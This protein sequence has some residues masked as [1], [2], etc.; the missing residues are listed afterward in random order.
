MPQYANLT[1]GG[2]L[3][4]V[5]WDGLN[6]GIVA[7]DIAKN[8][9]FSGQTIYLAAQES[10]G[11]GGRQ[12]EAVNGNNPYRYND[13]PGQAHASKAEGIAGTP[14]LL[15]TDGS[16]F[17]RTDTA[18]TVTLNA[19]TFYGYPGN[20]GTLADFNYAK[21]APGTAGAAA[22]AGATPGGSVW[23]LITRTL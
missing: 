17:D 1:L 2:Q 10:R 20:T 22:L 12:S 18:G 11:A 7:L 8:T 6:G 5:A 4:G 23:R 19:G 21:G 3:N 14:P 15:F 9:N 16:P 13:R